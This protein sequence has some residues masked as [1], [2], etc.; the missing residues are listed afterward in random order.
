[1][2]G[3]CVSSDTVIVQQRERERV[4]NVGVSVGGGALNAFT[5]AAT[6]S[7][8]LKIPA[9]SMTVGQIKLGSPFTD[10]GSLKIE[11]EAGQ[12]SAMDHTAR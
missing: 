10:C 5:A 4:G 11:G 8:H 6:A 2:L 12:G 9:A 3:L 1:M 7:H